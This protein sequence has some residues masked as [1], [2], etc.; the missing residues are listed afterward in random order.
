[1]QAEY[2]GQ[3]LA[4]VAEA[5]DEHDLRVVLCPTQNEHE[6]EVSLLV[7]TDARDDR[8]GHSIHPAESNEELLHA[9]QQEYPLVVIDPPLSIDRS[10]PVVGSAHWSGGRVATEHLLELGHL[11]IGVITARHAGM[12][13]RIVSR[14][15]GRP[16]RRV[17]SSRILS[18]Q[19]ATS[20]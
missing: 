6:R 7:A 20:R 14:A 1:M 11:R 2:F 13:A 3:L 9:R 12:R 18:W 17:E 16:Y 19:E 10:I 15:I 4:G 5:L 8:R